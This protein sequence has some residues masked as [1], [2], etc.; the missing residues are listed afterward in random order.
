[1]FGIGIEEG[2][3]TACGGSGWG[4]WTRVKLLLGVVDGLY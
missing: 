4:I 1:L 3:K 2:R